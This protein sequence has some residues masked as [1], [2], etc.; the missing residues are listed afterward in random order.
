MCDIIAKMGSTLL[1]LGIGWECSH[2]TWRTELEVVERMVFLTPQIF[3]VFFG[4][5][6][7][8]TKSRFSFGKLV[9]HSYLVMSVCVNTKSV[10]LLVVVIVGIW[11]KQ[12][13]IACGS[14]KKTRKVWKFT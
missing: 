7:F 8:L 3:G 14:V 10:P 9:I 11:R 13:Y 4:V 5:L 12:C 1:N 2:V 6:K